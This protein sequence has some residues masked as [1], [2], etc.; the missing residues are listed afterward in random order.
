[1]TSAPDPTSPAEGPFDPRSPQ[2]TLP[3][4]AAVAELR[5]VGATWSVVGPV[6]LAAIL[7]AG[8]VDGLSSLEVTGIVALFVL[9]VGGSL[10]GVTLGRRS[11]PGSVYI[12]ILDRAPAPP[13]RARLEADGEVATR[14]LLAAIAV[15]AGMAVAAAVGVALTLLLIGKP[16]AEVLDHLPAEV[17]LVTAGWTVVCGMAALRVAAWIARWEWRRDKRVLCR[18]LLAGSRRPVYYAADRA[19]SEHR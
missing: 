2:L 15:V 9:T 17:G 12:Q 10:A 5:W 19:R 6:G 8:S 3:L 11:G 1:M 14:A 18:A 16:R 7:V 13:A 4:V